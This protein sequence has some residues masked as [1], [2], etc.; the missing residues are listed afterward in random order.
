MRRWPRILAAAFVL[1]AACGTAR[2]ERVRF[3]YVPADGAGNVVIARSSPQGAVGERRSWYGGP[4]EP[5]VGSPR[6]N[7]VVTFRHP[8][9]G[10][11]V[12]VPLALPVDSTPRVEHRGDRTI[13]NYGSYTVETQFLPDGSV[14]VTYNSGFGRPLRVY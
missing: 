10:G 11:N 4:A 14:D 9:T 2:A 8:Y 12:N 1:A 3:H 13:F 7:Y 5:A 6:P